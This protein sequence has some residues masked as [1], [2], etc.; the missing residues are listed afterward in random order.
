MEKKQITKGKLFVCCR[1]W[2]CQLACTFTTGSV[3]GKE[4]QLIGKEVGGCEQRIHFCQMTFSTLFSLLLLDPYTAWT[5][6]FP[7]P[8]IINR[9]IYL[10]PVFWVYSCLLVAII[11]TSDYKYIDVCHPGMRTLEWLSLIRL[12][13]KCLCHSKHNNWWRLLRH[14]CVSV[15]MRVVIQGTD[16]HL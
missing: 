2:P 8:A 11:N 16:G 3:V 1:K 14:Q 13:C 12:P 4:L 5:V 7:S 10:S 6:V 9:S 15:A